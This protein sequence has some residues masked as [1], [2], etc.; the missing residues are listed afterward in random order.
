MQAVLN[1]TEPCYYSTLADD[2]D[3]GEIVEMFVDEMPG[4][5]RDLQTQ[6]RINDWDQLARLSHQLKGAAGS[7]GFDQITPYAAR[8]EKAVRN[9]LPHAEIQTAFDELVKACQRV[10]CGL[11]KC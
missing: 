5:I 3:L 9:E 1:P 4:R 8:C 7:Y 6:F 10:R 11:A 2:P